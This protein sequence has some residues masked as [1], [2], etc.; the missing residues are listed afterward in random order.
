LL[1]TGTKCGRVK[2]VNGIPTLPLYRF[3]VEA[4]LYR[5]IVEAHLYMFIVEAHLY[6]FIVEAHLYRFI[7]EAHLYKSLLRTG[8]KCGRVKQV[9]GIPTLPLLIIG[10]KQ[11]MKNLYRCASTINL[12]RCASF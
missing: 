2:Q 9:N 5:F 12:Y 1:R 11:T 10:C 3:I 6:R 4:H 8:T 7:V